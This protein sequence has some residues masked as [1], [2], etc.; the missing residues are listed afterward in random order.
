[1]SASHTDLPS[2]ELDPTWLE[3]FRKQVAAISGV[4]AYHAAANRAFEFLRDH[5]PEA[6]IA[7]AVTVGEDYSIQIEW[8]NELVDLEIEFYADQDTEAYVLFNGE[9]TSSMG[10][11][12][13][14]LTESKSRVSQA[15]CEMMKSQVRSNL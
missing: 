13:D 7:P 15:F 9:S 11:L 5:A 4:E 10:P 12:Q 3:G 1:M 6:L 2:L 14:D 8:H